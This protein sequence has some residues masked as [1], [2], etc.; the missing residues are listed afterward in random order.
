M[1]ITPYIFSSSIRPPAAPGAWSSLCKR[2]RDEFTA[3]E[4]TI[5]EIVDQPG[6]GGVWGAITGTIASQTDLQSALAA[7]AGST[8]THAQSDVTNLV[9]DLAGKQAAG[10]YAAA[11]HTHAQSDVT[12]L[13]TDLAGKAA[14]AHSHSGLAPAGGSADQVLKKSSATDYDYA[15]G[16]LSGSGLDY[17][18]VRRRVWM[19]AA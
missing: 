13:V 18:A 11:T 10:S 7:K 16:S 4:V 12:N 6:G 9:S 17:K 15:W 3:I 5:G 19:D 2:L 14:V 8:H 1:P